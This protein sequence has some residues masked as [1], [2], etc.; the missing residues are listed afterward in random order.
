VLLPRI[1]PVLL[2]HK[3][4][5]VKTTQFKNPKYVGDPINAVKIFNEKIV[6]EL[7][8]IDIDATTQDNSIDFNLIKNLASECRMPMSY[9]GGVKNIEQIEKIISLGV[10]KILISSAVVANP[11]LIRE[12]AERVG[13]QSIVVVLDVKKHPIFKKY[14]I[15]THN[16]KIKSDIKISDF[17][18]RI[19]DLGAGEVVVNSINN[20]GLMKGYDMELINIISKKVNIPITALGGAG[21]FNDIKSLFKNFGI[22]GA[23]VGS[24]FVFKGKYK[25]VLINY[26]SV[27]DKNNI[28]CEQ[29]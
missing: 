15:Y 11:E 2:V 20:D 9:G 3:G 4:G 24:M 19:I 28:Y 12:A 25:A 23:G 29:S 21:H 5:L 8:I 7:A 27:Y 1:I 18:E 14:S 26:P 22:I 17:L 13:S 10:E 16:G 6:D